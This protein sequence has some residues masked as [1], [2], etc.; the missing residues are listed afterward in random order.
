M[1]TRSFLFA[2]I[3]LM[4]GY[5]SLAQQEFVLNE[6]YNNN[7]NGWNEQ[8]GKEAYSKIKNGKYVCEIESGIFFLD[9]LITVNLNS[10]RD[11]V[12]ES[13]MT[14]K[15]GD[16]SYGITWGADG[17][18][19]RYNFVISSSGSYSI[20]KWTNYDVSFY[21]NSITSY[22]IKGNYSPNKL[23][24]KKEGG[25]L[26]F[27]VNDTYLQ[28]LPFEP[29]FGQKFGFYAN[30]GKMDIEVENY[31]IYYTTGSNVST[32]STNN[33]RTDLFV[34]YFDDNSKGWFEGN[35]KDIECKVRNGKYVIDYSSKESSYNLYNTAYIDQSR[36]Y[37][38]ES[39]I[40][41][42][43][44]VQDYGFGITFGY[45]DPNNKYDFLISSNGLFSV[46]RWTSGEYTKVIP[47]TSLS[48]IN[49][50]NGVNNKLTI[51]KEGN[52]LKFYIND[53]YADQLSLPSFYGDRFGFIVNKTQHIEARDIQIYY[54]GSA[55]NS[56]QVTPAKYTDIDLLVS[57][58]LET[59]DRN[60][61]A[62]HDIRKKFLA[63]SYMNARGLYDSKYK[64]NNY[65]IYGH[66]NESVS[67]GPGSVKSLIWGQDKSWIKR[68]IFTIVNENGFYYIYP[69]NLTSNDYIDPWSTVESNV[70]LNT[71]S[72]N[73]NLGEE[74]KLVTRFLE[75]IKSGN[76]STEDYLKSFLSPNYLRDK[77][78]YD[79]KYKVNTYTLYGFRVEDVDP[80][81]GKVT[82][83]IWGENKGWI[84]RL[85]FI[86]VK[87]NG[88]YYLYP[89][90]VSE[91]NYIYPW[92]NAET[93][94]SDN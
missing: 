85:H 31:K 13:T 86:V 54:T 56:G 77:G 45:K 8:S 28:D 36:N 61:S 94:V 26:K 1:K 41:K 62:T 82:A 57:D 39:N 84:H 88:S 16:V 50:G 4:I 80:Q 66:S 15:S 38:I 9:Q 67:N 71:G 34:D 75:A 5:N 81:T 2:F 78:L 3:I 93:N 64:V 32:F 6:E 87:E 19:S 44:G 90:K 48:S 24:I 37:V 76:N 17:V 20:H 29:F 59:F 18:G 58:F 83:K 21:A 91:Y 33:N 52:Y 11:F 40:Y 72:N 49:Q 55:S 7:Y 14:K 46:T 73:V 92:V 63:P 89:S 23:S 79:P 51:K 65:T 53:I 30:S 10:N 69:S 12:I 22:A 25:Y 60:T 35:E 43:D 70:S 47:W 68:L 42:V 27:Y 74:G